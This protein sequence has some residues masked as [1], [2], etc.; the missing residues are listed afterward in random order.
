MAGSGEKEGV[1]AGGTAVA[2]VVVVIGAKSS[3]V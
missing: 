3:V 2:V 1:D